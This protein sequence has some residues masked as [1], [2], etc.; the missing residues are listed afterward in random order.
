MT[1]EVVRVGTEQRRC[2]LYRHFDEHDILLY[3]GITEA[4]GDRT[5]NGHARSSEWVQFAVRAEAEW[6]DS[7]E[8]ASKA[9]REA[10]EDEQ[11][12]YNRQY[13]TGDTDLRITGYLYWRKEQ[14]L[15]GLLEAYQA[16]AAAIFD[17]V[18]DAVQKD[19]RARTEEDYRSAGHEPDQ[20]FG[21]YMLR[22]L[23][24]ILGDQAETLAEQATVDAYL[25][26]LGIATKR[27]EEIRDRRQRQAEEPPF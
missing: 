2:A 17:A 19:A 6:H 27:L 8:L 12:I 14:R 11:P 23:A 25:E 16:A 26:V 5:N 1:A 20:Q 4:L 15:Q 24:R 22:H 13:S 7:R 9:E 21:A 3:V 18:P 10:V